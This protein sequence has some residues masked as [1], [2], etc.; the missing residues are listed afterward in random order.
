MRMLKI[1][2]PSMLML[3]LFSSL[4]LFSISSAN[5]AV[6]GDSEPDIGEQ[7]DDGNLSAGDGCDATCQIES[8]FECTAALP[9][10]TTEN[11]LLNGSFESGATS[12][13]QNGVPTSPICSPA[14]CGDGTDYSIE[15]V[16]GGWF[17]SGG[18]SEASNA[19]ASQII[20]IPVTATN[21]EFA[22]WQASCEPEG[23]NGDTISVAIDGNE[24]YNSGTCDS[25]VTY[26]SFPSIGLA[27]YNDG[28]THVISITGIMDFTAGDNGSGSIFVDNI[29][30]NNPLSPP[31]PP[32]PSSCIQTF[33]SDGIKSGA[34]QCDDGNLINGDGCSDVCT[35]EFP[36]TDN[37]G[38]TDNLDNCTLVS[39]PDQL[40]T[41]GDGYGN[42][43]DTDLNNDSITNFIDVGMFRTAFLTTDA[44]ADFN[45]DGVVNFIDFAVMRTQFFQPPGPSWI[46]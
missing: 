1:K 20:N 43:C 5:A 28:A 31:I 46:D 39:N 12:W 6:C 44:D 14:T 27:P 17:W 18:V 8:E 21:L 11:L 25:A 3:A 10:Q 15:Q 19:T 22:V 42:L 4:C 38:V 30:L 16:G 29:S 33:C 32:V 36:D 23:G 45:G 26:N 24:I 13:S 41:N 34:E 35:I 7:C 40:D 37:D 2:S 9:G